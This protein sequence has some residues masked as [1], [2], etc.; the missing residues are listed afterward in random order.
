MPLILHNLIKSYIYRTTG[1]QYFVLSVF[2]AQCH[3]GIPVYLFK[4]LACSAHLHYFDSL[5]MLSSTGYCSIKPNIS[6]AEG[7]LDTSEYTLPQEDISFIV[8]N[9]CML[10]CVF[11]VIIKYIYHCRSDSVQLHLQLYLILP[12]AILYLSWHLY[13]F[14]SISRFCLSC[15][16]HVTKVTIGSFLGVTQKRSHC[17]QKFVLK[18]QSF[19]GNVPAGNLLTLA[20]ILYIGA[21]P[22][23][24]L[25]VLVCLL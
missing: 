5:E 17:Q 21:L 18:S 6:D 10:Y 23:K 19:I 24:A 15:T 14:F 25:W 2:S 12:L 1:C 13:S 9:S 11:S 16:V 8:N 7:G 4:M 20:A 22:T 3:M